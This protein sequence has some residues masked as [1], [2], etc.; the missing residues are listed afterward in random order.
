MSRRRWRAC[1]TAALCAVTVAAV[2]EPEPACAAEGSA[3][4]DVAKDAGEDPSSTDAV[5]GCSSLESAA[6]L[7]RIRTRS[8]ELDRR[9]GELATRERSVAA[10]EEK[11]E[12]RLVQLETLQTTLDQRLAQFVRDHGDRL[13]QLAKVYGRMPPKKAA[14]LVENLGRALAV[15]VVTRMKEKQIAALLGEMSPQFAVQLSRLVARPLA[16]ASYAAGDVAA[17]GRPGGTP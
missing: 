13:E 15:N 8:R 11:A 6:L 16:T 1:I 14:P 7:E 2:V 9:E 4:T 3:A 5:G 12:A 10:L 17:P